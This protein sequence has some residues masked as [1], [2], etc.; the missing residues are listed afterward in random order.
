[1]KHIK[2]TD[3]WLSKYM[4]IVDEAIIKEIE[5]QSCNEYN[6]SKKFKRKM[7]N[8]IWREKQSW[9]NT[10][11]RISKKAAVF[12]IAVL[13][14]MCIFTMSVKANR[15]KFFQT[16]KTIWEDSIVYSYFAEE[17]KIEFESKMPEYVPD[18]Y[19]LVME[20]K[21]E[22]TSVFIYQNDSGKQII[23]NQ[24]LISEEKTVVF[25]SEYD[26]EETVEIS[27]ESVHIYRYLD[28]SLYCYFEFGN[29]IYILNALELDNEAIEKIYNGWVKR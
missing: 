15:V 17:E 18:G 19:E 23:F 21:S 16:V 24:Q 1:M 4:P 5:R 10:F 2:V 28:G 25:D 12:A 6:F 22:I 29:S 13:G 9:M 27:G 20:N 8:I 3:E 26:F 7:K 11:Y 14:F